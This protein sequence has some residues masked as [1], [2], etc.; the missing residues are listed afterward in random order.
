MRNIIIDNSKLHQILFERGNIVKEVMKINEDIDNLEKE[1]N[2][3]GYKMNKLKDKTKIIIDKEKIELGEF[4][5]IANVFLNDNR[6]C[7][8]NILDNV[9][10]YKTMLREKNV[11]DNG[12]TK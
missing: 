3:L 10:E 11:K 6:E 2:K 9:E 4:E 1:R 8:L 7:E 5:F 12:A